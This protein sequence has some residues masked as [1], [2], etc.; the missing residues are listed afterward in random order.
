MQFVNAIKAEVGV[1]RYPEAE[2]KLK[3][4]LSGAGSQ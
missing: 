1:K 4:Q 2:A 3:R